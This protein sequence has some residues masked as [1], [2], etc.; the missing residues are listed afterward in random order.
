MKE[1]LL[2]FTM[3]SG[4]LYIMTG[5]F[6][7]GLLFVTVQSF[8]YEG[9]LEEKKKNN[10][11]IQTVLNDYWDMANLQVQQNP[12]FI[13]GFVRREMHL[14]K[15]GGLY[16][17]RLDT[18][19]MACLYISVLIGGCCLGIAL[20]E[21]VESSWD[22]WYGTAAVVYGAFAFGMGCLFQTWRSILAVNYKITRIKDNISEKIERLHGQKKESMGD[23]SSSLSTE[24]RFVSK[25]SVKVIIEE[26]KK[27]ESKKEETKKIEEAEKDDRENDRA[28]KDEEQKDM[29]QKEIKQKD[30]EQNKALMDEFMESMLDELFD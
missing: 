28:Q 5:M 26:S 20:L 1:F 6:L 12:Q 8:I 21:Y 15:W 18:L 16:I 11:W 29:K 2:Q 3:N 30:R 19:G 25:N 7:I 10:R 27:E 23:Q 22:K 17:E 14:W 24:K 9:I 13:D 4:M